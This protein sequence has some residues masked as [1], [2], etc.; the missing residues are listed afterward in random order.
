MI[1]QVVTNARQKGFPARDIQVL[2]PMYRG[3]AGIDS[4][5]VLLQGI[6]NDNR[7]KKKRELTFGDVVY[8]VGDKVLQLVNQPENGIYNGDMGE[9]IAII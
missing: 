8:R 6:L 2:A 3:S 4:L 9:I 1:R 5:N 7:D